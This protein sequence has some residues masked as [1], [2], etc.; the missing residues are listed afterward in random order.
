ASPIA[1]STY[2]TVLRAFTDVLHIPLNPLENHGEQESL[3][4]NRDCIVQT[5]SIARPRGVTARGHLR[6]RARSGDG[7]DRLEPCELV[8]LH[9]GCGAATRSGWQRSGRR[10]N[11]PHTAPKATCAHAMA[12]STCAVRRSTLSVK[13]PPVWSSREC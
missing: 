2:G 4:P 8:T 9:R 5:G 6:Q 10:G 3:R 13:H 1:N 12:A 11:S 7:V